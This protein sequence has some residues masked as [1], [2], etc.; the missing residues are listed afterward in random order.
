MPSSPLPPPILV[1]DEESLGRVVRE[2]ASYP[3]VAVDTESNSLHA[4]RE[5]VCL[6]QFSTPVADYIVDP[7]KVA[8]LSALGPFFANPDQQK[9]F[10]A[11]EYDLLCL[12]RDYRFEF[13]NIF[14]TMSTARTLGWPQVG[15]AAILGTHFGVTMNKKY[16]RADWKHRPL[17]PE[18]LDYARLDTHYLV[19]LRDKQIDALHEAGRSR[20]A[21]EEFERLARVGD[22]PGSPGSP[23]SHDNNAAP[24]P[25]AFW[26]VKGS[27]DL[28]PAQAAVLQALFAYREQQ[29]ERIDR[30]PFKVMGEETL[31]A[32][33]RLAP[34][35]VESLKGVPGMTPD[36]IQ[37]HAHGV[38]QAIQQG[39]DAPPQHAPQVEREPNDVRD[40]YDRLHTW[41]KERAKARGVESD[42]ILPRTALWDLA[43]RPPRTLDELAH[44]TD[45]GPWRRETY[46]AEILA[47]L[48]SD[49]NA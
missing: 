35:D 12:K 49:A 8:D 23:G 9:V 15:L 25:A 27:R 45:F 17:T 24:N 44:I 7:I 22:D 40:R 38:L 20:E 5:R 18:Q 33:V 2:L 21:H 47:L 42:V 28:T 34:R 48:A 37:R 11:A 13:A 26:R 4:Y 41:R 43:R 19:A 14:D 32:L 29:A 10:H 3:V 31:M 30:P 6:I 1:A 16:Q 36:Q 46:G 39:L